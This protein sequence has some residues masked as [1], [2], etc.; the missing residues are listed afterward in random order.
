MAR[1]QGECLANTGSTRS[2]CACSESTK[3]AVAVWMGHGCQ[4]EEGCA[5]SKEGC[6][7]VRREVKFG[8]PGLG[9]LALGSSQPSAKRVEVGEGRAGEG[10]ENMRHHICFAGTGF[11]RRAM[12]P[13]Q[14]QQ[15]LPLGHSQGSE[16]TR[17]NSPPRWQGHVLAEAQAV[18]WAVV[19]AFLNAAMS[20]GAQ[21]SLRVC[22]NVSNQQ[23]K[24]RKTQGVGLW[25]LNKPTYWLGG[26]GH[27]LQA[28]AVGQEGQVAEKALLFTA[29]DRPGTA[30]STSLLLSLVDPHHALSFHRKAEALRTQSQS[31]WQTITD[32]PLEKQEKTVH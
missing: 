26:T 15:H 21:G 30:R 11:L 28:R 5:H 18:P 23:S 8:S 1:G 17:K 19:S 29:N 16:E 4:E 27:S 20:V 25:Q 10:K 3:G 2:V 32:Q 14:Q 31:S 24:L 9:H 13:Q 12:T 22:Q 6:G 7:A